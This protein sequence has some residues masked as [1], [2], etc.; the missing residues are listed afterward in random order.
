MQDQGEVMDPSGETKYI[1]KNKYL[2]KL[3][4]PGVRY[5]N[6]LFIL[7]KEAAMFHRS[8]QRSLL[9]SVAQMLGSSGRGRRDQGLRMLDCQGGNTLGAPKQET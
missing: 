5:S 7:A 6:D 1:L 3:K 2:I 8:E 9:C 4:H